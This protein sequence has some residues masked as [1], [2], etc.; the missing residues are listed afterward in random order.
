MLTLHI[1]IILYLFPAHA[2]MNRYVMFRLA[3]RL[4]C[5]PRTRG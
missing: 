2:G 1:E 3:Q 4:S 5:S